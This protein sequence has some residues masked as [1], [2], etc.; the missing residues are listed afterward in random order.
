MM[1]YVDPHAY[2]PYDYRTD[3]TRRTNSDGFWAG[4]GR[5]REGVHY[6][7]LPDDRDRMA[8][9]CYGMTEGKEPPKP[10]WQSRSFYHGVVVL[11]LALWGSQNVDAIADNPEAV[12]GLA[13]VLG[14]LEIAIRAVTRTAIR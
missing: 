3:P 11:A 2:V 10:L 7:E 14:V 8:G 13:A 1:P 4:Y 9:W 6:S 12:A 5:Y